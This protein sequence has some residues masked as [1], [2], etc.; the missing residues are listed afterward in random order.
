MAS[1]LQHLRGNLVAYLALFAALTSGGYAAT[2]K[3]LPPNSV[4]TR[5]VING[6]LLKKD[7]RAGQLPR[8]ARGPTGQAGAAGATGLAGPAGPTGQTGAAGAKGPPGPV[9]VLYADSGPIDVGPGFTETDAVACPV[10]WVAVGGGAFSYDE[11]VIDSS[12]QLGFPYWPVPQ[13]RGWLAT[14]EN[15]GAT[16]GSY[17]L[18]A[19]CVQATDV[20]VSTSAS[21][22]VLRLAKG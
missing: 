19:I 10:G 15:G 4:G 14:V 16:A 1:L 5:Q 20:F 2:T 21:A 11:V 9:S 18:D 17:Y 12:D 22:K 13:G 3:L 6:S 8:G 7:F